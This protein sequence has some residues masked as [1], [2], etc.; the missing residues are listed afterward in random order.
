MIES[1]ATYHVHCDRCRIRA[2]Q[3]GGPTFRNEWDAADWINERGDWEPGEEEDDYLVSAGQGAKA[4][5]EIFHKVAGK[6]Y[7]EHCT[8]KLIEATKKKP[9][10]THA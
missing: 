2:D 1:E 9:E 3:L 8:T 6:L 10:T 7:C 4:V 5:H